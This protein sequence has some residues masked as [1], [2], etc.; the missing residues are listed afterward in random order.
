MLLSV[1]TFV[2]LEVGG[3][4]RQRSNKLQICS[5]V[6]GVLR[7]EIMFCISGFWMVS[8]T[9][10]VCMHVKSEGASKVTMVSS[11]ASLRS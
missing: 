1:E 4:Y 10:D 7:S 6:K 11:G 8:T 2:L 9:L 5:G 3:G